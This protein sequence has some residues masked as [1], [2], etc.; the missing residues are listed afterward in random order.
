MPVIVPVTVTV[1]SH[2][3]SHW[4]RKHRVA[5]V[6]VGLRVT[7]DLGSGLFFGAA[8]LMTR[9]EL[10]ELPRGQTYLPLRTANS[11]PY[12]LV[13]SGSDSESLPQATSR[14]A[15]KALGLPVPVPGPPGP[16]GPPA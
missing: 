6:R 1:T 5:D 9:M 3:L 2:G 14:Q 13:D 8:I 15:R 11:H 16:R 10:A 4:T 7:R 12:S